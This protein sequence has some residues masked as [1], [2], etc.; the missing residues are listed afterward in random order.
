MYAGWEGTKAEGGV[1]GIEAGGVRRR[2]ER[3][4]ETM[5]DCPLRSGSRVWAYLRVS[6]GSW[7]RL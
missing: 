3:T 4:E 6:G 5:S 1:R 2:H 7:G